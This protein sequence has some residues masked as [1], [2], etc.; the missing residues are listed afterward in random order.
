MV[1][2]GVIKFKKVK[3]EVNLKKSV[4]LAWIIF[5]VS[6]RSPYAQTE[7]Y[8]PLQVGNK[9]IYDRE[10]VDGYV[11]HEVVDTL[12]IHKNLYYSMYKEMYSPIWGTSTL[13][14]Y[15]RKDSLNQ[16]WFAHP[17]TLEESLTFLRFHRAP[18]LIDCDYDSINHLTTVTILRDTGFTAITPAGTFNHCYYFY[19]LLVEI[20][21]DFTEVYAPDVGLVRATSE[22]EGMILKGAIINGLSFG[23]TTITRIEKACDTIGPSSALLFQNYPNPFNQNTIITYSLNS[24][25]PVATKLTIYDIAGK[26]VMTLIDTIQNAGQYVVRWNGLDNM[27]RKVG[28]GPYIYQLRTL[29]FNSSRMLLIT[30]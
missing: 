15:Y 18:G 8:F 5:S 19:S 2:L 17:K 4:F 30:K 12:L 22:G 16:V 28:S 3:K 11:L 6:G 26:E 9:W 27:G 1:I 23:D 25:S 20:Y 10:G 14:Y 24:Q 21:T 13:F 7:D 29:G